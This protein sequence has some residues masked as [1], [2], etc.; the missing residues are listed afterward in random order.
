MRRLLSLAAVAAALLLP[1]TAAADRGKAPLTVAVIGDTPYGDEQ[2][3]AFPRLVD[4]VNA[5]RRVRLVLHLGDIKNGSSTCTDERFLSLRALYETFEDPFAYTPG[6]NEWTDCHR[7][8]AGGYL[9][10]ERLD[11]LREIFYPEPGRTLGSGRRLR[12]D[13]Q[14]DE[15]G[16]ETFVENQR[17]SD[18]RVVFSLLHVVGSSNGLAPWFGSAETPA[19]R[20][21]RLAEVADRQEASLAWLEAT[22]AQARAERARGVVLGMQAD[23]FVRPGDP[24]FAAL[25]ERIAQLARTFRGP[26]LLLQGDTHRYLVDRP[27]PTAPNVTRIVVEGETADEWL[28]LT[29]SPRGRSLFAWE[30]RILP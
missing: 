4:D 8:A 17:W 26:V 9:P 12:V 1:A 23:T 15:A 11:R 10:T 18:A 6:D 19:Q 3:A 27:L 14:A 24:G 25:V 5:D 20:E 30:R 22:F 13:I 16:F 29:V 2:V 7:P 21:L 28:R